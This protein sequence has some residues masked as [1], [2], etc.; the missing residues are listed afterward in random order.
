MR[1][2][3]NGKEFLNF[4]FCEFS[5]AGAAL[6]SDVGTLLDSV[7]I[8]TINLSHMDDLI[9]EEITQ[10]KASEPEKLAELLRIKASLAK[11]RVS[12]ADEKFGNTNLYFSGAMSAIAAGTCGVLLFTPL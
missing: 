3:P 5:V 2:D 6:Y 8:A 12:L 9:D 7:D 11:Q 4:V 1:Y 10:C